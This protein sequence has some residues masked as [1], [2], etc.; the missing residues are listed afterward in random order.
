MEAQNGAEASRVLHIVYFLSRKGYEEHPHL[1]QVEHHS[2]NG[3]QLQDI[4]R[5]LGEL[6]G[7]DMPKS[8]AWSYKR[9]YKTGYV[10]QDL[11]DDDLIT[12]ISD[13]EYVLQGSEIPCTVTNTTDLLS[14]QEIT[15]EKTEQLASTD[16]ETKLEPGKNISNTNKFITTA[17]KIDEKGMTRFSMSL[18][19]LLSC[20]G[21]ETKES[22]VTIARGKPKKPP[23]FLSICS[24]QTSENVRPVCPSFHRSI[25]EKPRGTQHQRISSNTRKSYERAKEMPTYK[26]LNG[27]N[28][29]QC[30]KIFK[31]EKMH[32]HMKSCR[33][34]MSKTVHNKANFNRAIFFSSYDENKSKMANVMIKK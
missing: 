27:P 6:R 21:T 11:L 34:S 26:P 28:C 9:R 30:G 4:K 31:P 20:R 2:K 25:T 10:W 7:K 32:A 14:Y 33:G 5:W 3:V 1:I 29:A 17:K 13:N 12:P 18:R 16:L 15:K 19:S 24:G 23:S 22:A 8:F